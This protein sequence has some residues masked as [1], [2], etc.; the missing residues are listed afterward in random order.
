MCALTA[1]GLVSRP[2]ER[3]AVDGELRAD[4]LRRGLL[5]GLRVPVSHRGYR[6]YIGPVPGPAEGDPD[7]WRAHTE[8]PDGRMVERVDGPLDDLVA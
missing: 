3:T 7:R 2:W 8:A 4:G 6:A 1:A 5:S